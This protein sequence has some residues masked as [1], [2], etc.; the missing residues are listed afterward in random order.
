MTKNPILIR[1]LHV[2][3]HRLYIL[4]EPFLIGKKK[5]LIVVRN[6][7]EVW[8]NNKSEVGV[9][10]QGWI[11]GEVGSASFPRVPTYRLSF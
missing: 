1:T 11:I 4:R 5:K 6:D 7:S 10:S 8:L 9:K 3:G 2:S